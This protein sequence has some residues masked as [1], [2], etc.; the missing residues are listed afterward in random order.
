VE[1]SPGIMEHASSHVSSSLFP[2]PHSL[3][4][5]GW[6][7]SG[8]IRK[9]GSFTAHLEQELIRI[10]RGGVERELLRSAYPFH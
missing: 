7:R 2:S 8:R 3:S 1:P 9:C 4:A 6:I 5:H 10:G